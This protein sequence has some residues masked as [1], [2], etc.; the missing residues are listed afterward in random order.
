M[1]TVPFYFS[2]LTNV[3]NNEVVKK[4]VYDKLVANV[5][6]IYTSGFVL[7]TRYDTNKKMT[8]KKNQWCWQKIPSMV[9]WVKK[10]I[11]IPRLL[12]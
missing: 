9:G 3:L 6:N 12:K 1:K 4:I 10:Q 11:I 7:K 5:D 2:N 8:L